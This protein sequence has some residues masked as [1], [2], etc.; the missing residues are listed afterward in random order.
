VCTTEKSEL[1]DQSDIV[2]DDL[3]HP[4]QIAAIL[5]SSD[6]AFLVIFSLELF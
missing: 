2:F 3:G 1:H 5:E 4:T 6:E